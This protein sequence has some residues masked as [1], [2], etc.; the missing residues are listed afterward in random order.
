[1]KRDKPV[2]SCKELL[3]RLTSDL[4]IRGVDF[5]IVSNKGKFKINQATSIN[6]L[7]MFLNNVK[8]HKLIIKNTV[9]KMTNFNYTFQDSNLIIAYRNRKFRI[10]TF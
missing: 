6:A 5:E 4:M 3:L 7:N 10:I 8:V 2:V 1:M 9:I